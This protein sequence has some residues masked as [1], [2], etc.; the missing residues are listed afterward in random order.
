MRQTQKFIAAQAA[1]RQLGQVGE[2]SRAI[3]KRSA[4]QN[5]YYSFLEKQG[6]RW[7]SKRGKWEKFEKP[8]NAISTGQIDIRLRAPLGDIEAAT[9]L[10]GETL[11][12]AGC[13][14]MR[15]SPPDPD[16]RDG[17]ATTGRVY[18]TIIL[19]K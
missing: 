10:I 7:D 15:L 4:D 14:F 8:K 18:M 19:P 6:Y 3:V 1:V 17:P 5:D 16:D 12:A 11:Q 2:G 13:Q 9:K